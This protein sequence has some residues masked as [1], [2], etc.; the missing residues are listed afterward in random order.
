VS[1][2]LRLTRRG[3]T[4]LAV[5][6]A[7]L[8]GALFWLAALSAP[9]TS[10]PSSVPAAGLAPAVVQVHPGDTLWLIAT[11]VAPHADP[12]AEVV[13]LQRL[14]HLAGAEVMPGQLLRT[15]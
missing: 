8:A 5:A 6:V 1:A 13:S 10:A 15:R 2:P 11:R 14:N 4:V 7:V 12:R 9:S 3:V